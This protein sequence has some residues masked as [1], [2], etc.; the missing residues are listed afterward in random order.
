MPLTVSTN[1]VAPAERAEYWHSVLNAHYLPVGVTPAPRLSRGY[2]KRL[3]FGGFVVDEVRGGPG[4][5]YRDARLARDRPGEHVFL[6]VLRRGR[7]VI[8][9]DQRTA[10]LSAP[11]D[12]CLSDTALPY[13]EDL[14]TYTE[15]VILQVPR[16][17]LVARVPELS[18]MTA[19]RCRGDRGLGAA[20]ASLVLALPSQDEDRPAD[21]LA[22]AAGTTAA[23]LAVGALREQLGTAP[24]TSPKAELLARAQRFML[25]NQ[26]VGSLSPADVARAVSVS[27]RYL[28]V[29]FRE[30]GCS[31]AAWLHDTRMDQARRL[32]SRLARPPQAGDGLGW[33][34][35]PFWI[36]K[37]IIP[38][39]GVRRLAAAC[40]ALA[41][42]AEEVDQ[43]GGDHL[44]RGVVVV[45]VE[46]L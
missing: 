42:G 13:A 35:R 11:G 5:V 12:F 4:G 31:P 43:D 23:D 17:A 6:T 26:H 34:N 10:V 18:G 44:G 15:K 30:A 3:A 36:I 8:A 38:N 40:G 14:A 45:P 1:D 22:D 19:V 32:G 46:R 27:E 9:Q 37:K 33:N 39:G 29:L 20:A 28:F 2:L 21:P 41:V 7:C 16:A 24:A 25:D